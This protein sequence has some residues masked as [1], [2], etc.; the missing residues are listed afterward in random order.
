MTQVY[1][2]QQ[3]LAEQYYTVSNHVILR[4]EPEESHNRNIVEILHFTQDDKINVI[5]LAQ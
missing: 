1:Y 2:H 4:V 5:W 3:M